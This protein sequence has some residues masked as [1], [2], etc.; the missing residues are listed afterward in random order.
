M[1]VACVALAVALGGTSYAVTQ[2]P[3]NSVGTPQLK[4]DAVTSLKIKDR[5]I[6]GADVN[7]SKLGSNWKWWFFGGL[8]LF[9]SGFMAY[10]FLPLTS[11]AAASGP[12][13]RFVPR[14][15]ASA[16][17]SVQF[18]SRASERV[19]KS[20]PIWKLVANAPCPASKTTTTV[21]CAPM[22]IKM[23]RDASGALARYAAIKAFAVVVTSLKSS[24]S[25]PRRAIRSRMSPSWQSVTQNC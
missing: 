10:L 13:S 7:K 12:A 4:K 24:C 1:I 18:R 3:N 8:L 14:L 11:P 2:I 16:A 25:S 20:P 6:V 9:A 21:V 15:S 17:S 23:A 19:K 22:W 5:T